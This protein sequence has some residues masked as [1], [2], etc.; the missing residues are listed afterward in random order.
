MPTPP[1]T[2]P[3]TAAQ[4][5][6]IEH[7]ILRNP[8]I[9]ADIV[10]TLKQAHLLTATEDEV[11]YGGAVGGGK[12]EALL[13]AACQ[14]K[15]LPGSNTLI[16]RESRESLT[17][18]GALVP[19][20]KEYLG[21]TDARWNGS[22]FTW[23]FPNGNVIEFGYLQDHNIGRHLSA[24]YADVFFEE[25]TDVTKAAYAAL[26]ARARRRT[27]NPLPVR[28]RAT[29]NPPETSSGD[30]I[31][32]RFIRHMDA[33]GIAASD[34]FAVS[35][36]GIETTR[37]FIGATGADNPHLDV[38]SYRRTLS[39][40]DRL[41]RARMLGSWTQA[42]E[43]KML[44]A[45]HLPIVS[46]PLHGPNVVRC[47]AWD[48]AATLPT[49]KS[50][51]PDWTVGVVIALDTQLGVYQVQGAHYMRDIPAQVKAA[52]REKAQSDGIETMLRWWRDP[53]Q[54]GKAQSMDLSVM[55]G[56]YNASGVTARTNKVTNFS[57]FAAA[58][59]NGLVSVLDFD[60]AQDYVNN[61]LSFP[62]KGV[63]DDDVDATSLSYGTLVPFNEVETALADTYVPD[64]PA[65][66]E[67]ELR[68]MRGLPPSED[69]IW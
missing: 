20:S 62:T 49:T 37:R 30:W 32:E 47:R 61:L 22:T 1:E 17:K 18:A 35:E 41:T 54:A 6:L 3:L 11:L 8:Y 7:S 68:R 29:C 10:P 56:A 24:E 48:L 53:A 27:G 52:I 65:S 60:G 38:V 12:S 59:G 21:D 51:D 43:G 33:S 44:L 42:R 23:T 19:R 36:D 39:M 9:P 14:Y 69:A 25:V 31:R 34:T 63:H 15:H 45:E 55:M 57:P 50:P 67:D 13:M 16:V 5:D 40:A 58:A 46:N 64:D 28:I 66:A 4:L 2:A 26:A